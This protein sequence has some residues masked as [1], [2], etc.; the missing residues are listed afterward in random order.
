[1]KCLIFTG[2]S[3][4]LE[5]AADFVAAHSHDCII[6][7]DKGISYCLSL[8]IKPDYCLGDFDSFPGGFEAA[9]KQFD[10]PVKRYPCEKDDTD[11]WLALTAAQKLGAGQILVL[12]ATG[13]RLDHVAANLGNLLE[14]HRKGIKVEIFDPFN[15]IYLMEGKREFLR[16]EMYG[17][18]VSV[19]PFGNDL[20]GVTYRGFKYGMEEGGIPFGSSLGVSNELVLKKGEISIRTGIAAIFETRD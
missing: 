18:Y 1:M 19:L 16:E 10:G 15:R 3:L 5:W 11:T 9:A 8:G 12:G 14:F 7:A 6:A 4:N 17:P 2:G 20:E 13:T